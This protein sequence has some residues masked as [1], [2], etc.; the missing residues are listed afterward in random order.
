MAAGATMIR[1]GVPWYKVEVEHGLF[2]WSWVDEVL[3]F[4]N[5]KGIEP[6]VDLVHYGTPLWLT[7]SFIDARFLDVLEGFTR[8]FARRYKHRVRY[9][10]PVNE[11]TVNADFCGRRGLWPPYLSGDSGYVKVLL[12]LARGIQRSVKAIREE[13]EHSI[14][15]AVEAMNAYRPNNAAAASAV[16]LAYS[17]GHALL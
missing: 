11:P 17:K 9:Y 8:A 3:N 10:T 6:I 12:Q 4:M 15:F 7:E 13:Q 14:V 5:E 2:E 16:A 1:W